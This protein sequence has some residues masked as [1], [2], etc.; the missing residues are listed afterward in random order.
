MIGTIVAAVGTLGLYWQIYLTRRAVEDTSEATDA[1]REANRLAREAN[2]RPLRPYVAFTER[3]DEDPAPFTRESSK[4][5]RIK[6]F[7][8]TP[9]KSVILRHGAAAIHDP[10]I[11]DYVVEL[12][13]LAPDYGLLPPGDVRDDF[14]HMRDL[15]VERFAAFAA[16]CRFLI[17]LRIDYAWD[18]GADFHDLTMI[19]SDPAISRWKLPTEEER[20][21]P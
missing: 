5:F 19:L 15:P 8:Q 2:D 7:G 14:I 16:G 17:R 13:E 9:A 12:Q 4:R 21:R 20:Q 10:P 3:G 11:G 1:M 18:G 6:N